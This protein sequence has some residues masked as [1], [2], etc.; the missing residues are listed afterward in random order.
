MT[1]WTTITGWTGGGEGYDGGGGAGAVGLYVAGSSTVVDAEGTTAARKITAT[2][3]TAPWIFKD[4]IIDPYSL[5]K[6]GDL[7]RSYSAVKLES[8]RVWVVAATIMS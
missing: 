3:A 5:S 8:E 1:P 7:A 4:A 2:T 6:K